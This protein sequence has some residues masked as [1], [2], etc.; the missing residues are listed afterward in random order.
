MVLALRTRTPVDPKLGIKGTLYGING[1][2]RVIWRVGDH[3]RTK[4]VP[5]APARRMLDFPPSSTCSCATGG[6]SW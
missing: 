1:A 6:Q 3:G 4:L 5:Q 2:P